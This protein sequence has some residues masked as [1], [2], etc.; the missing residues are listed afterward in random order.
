MTRQSYKLSPEKELVIL[1]FWAQA[2]DILRSFSPEDVE[3]VRGLG[4]ALEAARKLPDAIGWGEE[5][6]NPEAYGASCE[7]A[8]PVFRSDDALIQ[9]DSIG[10]KSADP[11][12]TSDAAGAS[13]GPGG[14]LGEKRP[15][16]ASATLGLR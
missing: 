1:Q 10:Q 9:G 12:F 3:A 11:L 15:A 5:E 13:C 4:Q 8:G 14:P 2:V 7:K 16:F 6:E